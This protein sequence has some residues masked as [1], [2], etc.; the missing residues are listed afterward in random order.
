MN[1]D[2]TA[3]NSGTF[4]TMT[5]RAT[6][7]AWKRWTLIAGVIAGTIGASKAVTPLVAPLFGFV[8]QDDLKWRTDKI[9]S[10]E[11]EVAAKEARLA[12]L[13]AEVIRQKETIQELKSDIRE[14]RH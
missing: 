12:V 13:E 10:L 4:K 14:L 2:Q 5:E 1:G 11:R 7:S 8:V 6:D 9:L 3:R